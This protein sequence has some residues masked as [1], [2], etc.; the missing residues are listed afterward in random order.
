MCVSIKEYVESHPKI[1]CSFEDNPSPP[2]LEIPM[3]TLY[4]KNSTL[5]RFCAIEP[6]QKNS[7]T[8]SFLHQSPNFVKRS[9][10]EHL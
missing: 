6:S 9:F 10:E 7:L 2:W 4:F 5:V 3:Y 1:R 8:G